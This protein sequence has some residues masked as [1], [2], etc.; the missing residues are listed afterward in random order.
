LKAVVIRVPAELHAAVKVKAA[1]EERSMAQAIRYALHRYVE[2][3]DA[4]H[5]VRK[6]RPYTAA[7]SFTG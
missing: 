6:S 5:E 1:G 3:G 4:P 7:A 2:D